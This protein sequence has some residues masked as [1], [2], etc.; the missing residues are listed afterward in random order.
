MRF[1]ATPSFYIQQATNLFAGVIQGADDGLPVQ[2]FLCSRC[3]LSVP[4]YGNQYPDILFPV[5]I[6]R[7]QDLTEYFADSQVAVRPAQY[8]DGPR[9]VRFRLREYSE[10]TI[11]L[12]WGSSVLSHVQ[13]A[14]PDILRADHEV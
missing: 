1:R 7:S 10:G 14:A 11:S 6:V 2:L 12:L 9:P 5:K 3:S 13:L 4:S 8:T